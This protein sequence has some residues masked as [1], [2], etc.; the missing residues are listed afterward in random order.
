[1][2]S[3]GPDLVSARGAKLVSSLAAGVE[4]H[5]RHVA[6]SAFAAGLGAVGAGLASPAAPALAVLVIL[7]AIRAPRAGLVG[8]ALFLA[9]GAVAGGRVAAIDAAGERLHPGD[10]VAGRGYLLGLPRP[11]AFGASVE[12]EMTTGSAQGAKLL[13]RL[14]RDQHLP[15]G[16]GPGLE[17]ALS[18]SFRHPRVRPG[19]SFDVRAYQRRRGIAGEVS[20]LTLRA[21]GGRRGGVSGGID[22]ARER[23][24]HAVAHGLSPPGGALANGMVL[25][26]DERIDS[27]V[28]D[29]FK[30]S[31]LAHVLAVSGQNVMLLGALS[32][33]L[34]AA[35]GAGHG[36]RLGATVVLIAIY[37]P[38]AG[39]GP[40]LQRAGVMGAASLIALGVSRP[41]S[42]WYTL[43]LAA[44]VTLVVN[45]RASGD[46]GWQLSFVAVAGIL[47]LAPMLRGPL[48]PL[49]RPL[50]EGIAITVAATLAT[51]PLMGHH[52]GSVALAGLPANVLALPLVAPIMW[53]GMI[54]AALGQLG[55]PVQPL[56]DLAGLPLA[57]A[58]GALSALATSFAAM[59][60][61]QLGLPLGSRAAVPLAYGVLGAATFLVRRASRRVDVAPAAGR[62]RRARPNARI[63]VVCALGVALA[64]ALTRLTAAPAPPDRLTV[65]FLDV[66]QGDATLIQAPG[67]T[68]VL[69]DGGPPEGGVT[70]LLRRAGVGRLA[71]VVAT[72]QSR[73]H[74]RGLQAV[75]EG[76]RIG[77]L[78]QNGDGTHDGSFGRMVSTARSRGAQVLAPQPGQVLRAGPL[79][80]R[81]YGPPSRPPG[82][83]PED[84]NPRAIAAVVSYGG[85]DLFLSGD[86]ES[87]ALAQYDLPPVEAMKVSHHGSDDPGLP[88]LLRRL[89]PRM[90]GI[91]VG[92]ANTYGH[93]RPSTIA[94]LRRARVDTYRTDQDGTI[95][96]QTAPDG[97]LEV[98]EK[99]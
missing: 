64:L 76:Y 98:T 78:L 28:R 4:R 54:R 73:D 27:A 48:T 33:P 20:A 55:Q 97:S 93:P 70:R 94:A 77:T 13:V 90:A 16:A 52:F 23:A 95:R 61:G 7:A 60:G 50:A 89:R 5:L 29:D 80:V 19:A 56:I 40:S 8:A 88:E 63:A 39:A 9:G 2:I 1:M 21:T 17:V 41:S 47:I 72:H 83:P 25:G 34:L 46:P 10:R 42:R 53:L 30:A 69:F 66:G 15:A 32:L 75:A 57:P 44:C 18:G 99:R 6:L 65:S 82:S 35:L 79:S 43:L 3:W 38:L 37:V 51:A 67:G 96:L 62:W 11:G 87:D 84:P 81:I 22:R 85:F 91:E 12:V 92:E 71:L 26:Q 24:Q 14:G 59:P 45:P 31:G 36:A 86:A 68:A 74:H 58:L 49:P